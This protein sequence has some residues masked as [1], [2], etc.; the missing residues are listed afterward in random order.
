[1]PMA[2]TG[3]DGEDNPVSNSFY[4]SAEQKVTIQQS[5]QFAFNLYKK[6]N[7]QADVANESNVLS[8]LSVTYMLGML[9]AGIEGEGSELTAKLNTGVVG[10]HAVYFEFLMEEGSTATFDRFTFG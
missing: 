3:C 4:L 2:F 8:P 7:N 5:N 1:M 9:N 6:L 10:K